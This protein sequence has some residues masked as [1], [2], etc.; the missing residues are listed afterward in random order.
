MSAPLPEDLSELGERTVAKERVAR[1]NRLAALFRRW[2][3]LD[4]SEMRELR[5]LHDER[6]RIARYVGRR[7]RRRSTEQR[8]PH[9]SSGRDGNAESVSGGHDHARSRGSRPTSSRSSSR[10]AK[11]GLIEGGGTR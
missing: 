1:D 11:R 4:R 5:R 8:L 3:N 10:E 6:M 2:G 9:S 7:R